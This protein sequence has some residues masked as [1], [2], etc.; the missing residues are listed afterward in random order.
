MGGA[1]YKILWDRVSTR[2]RQRAHQHHAEC[3]FGGAYIE[4]QQDKNFDHRDI[5]QSSLY[6]KRG[7]DV[8]VAILL[9][10]MLSP[11]LMIIATTLKLESSGPIIFAQRRVGFK[12]KIFKIYKFR[13]MYVLEDGAHVSSAKKDDVRVTQFGY[14]IRRTSI[15][16]LPQLINV[17]RG[18]MSLVGP[19]PHAVV[20]DQYYCEA[21]PNYVFRQS[22][23]PGM[24]GW[25]QVNGCRGEIKNIDEI[26]NR[27]NHDTW[28][29][30]NRSLLLDFQILLRTA[31]LIIFSRDCY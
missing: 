10:I 19:R 4:C 27:V 28:Y 21:V 14:W 9:L 12:G 30:K 3:Q 8:T 31:L 13:S 25:A 16:E 6:L 22:V 2:G 7:L 18:E 29:I 23:R 5:N 1:S 26:T 11:L 20:Q 15:D 24:T 17:V